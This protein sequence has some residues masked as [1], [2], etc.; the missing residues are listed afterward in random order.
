M[1]LACRLYSSRY[2]SSQLVGWSVGRSF[3][4]LVGW[5]G[6]SVIWSVSHLVG[7][8]VGR[9][10]G[11]SVTN[12]ISRRANTFYCP[13]PTA[14]DWG[15]CVNGLVKFPP[16]ELRYR[17]KTHQRC[18]ID[19]S[20]VKEFQT[21]LRLPKIWSLGDTVYVPSFRWILH[22][23]LAVKGE[24]CVSHHLVWGNL[25]SLVSFNHLS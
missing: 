11:Q 19:L 10:V 5:S 22:P 16:L 24:R 21:L 2:T 9:P 14:R 15:S 18:E 25:Y 13:C 7:R 12:T 1:Y 23:V 17:R 20:S 6:R 4:R 8:S 3:G